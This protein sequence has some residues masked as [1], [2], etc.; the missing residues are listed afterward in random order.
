[1]RIADPIWAWQARSPKDR[2]AQNP[3]ME[4]RRAPQ[5]RSG[6]LAPELSQRASLAL[7]WPL[8]R[9]LPTGG[10]PQDSLI[11]MT[12]PLSAKKC[13][14]L[15]L[16]YPLLGVLLLYKIGGLRW[17]SLSAQLLPSSRRS[18]QLSP[19]RLA[20]KWINCSRPSNP[21]FPCGPL[22]PRRSAPERIVFLPCAAGNRRHPPRHRRCAGRS[23]HALASAHTRPT[24]PL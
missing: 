8:V 12:L 4:R 15:R 9:Y 21:E 6:A 18:S 1:M 13:L 7:S 20:P 22:R 3:H 2:L 11:S 14:W 24:S 19:F 10:P 23:D 5:C 17:I 16:A